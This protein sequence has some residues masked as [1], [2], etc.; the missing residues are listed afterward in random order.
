MPFCQCLPGNDGSEMA[1]GRMETKKAELEVTIVFDE[2][3]CS[4]QRAIS[5]QAMDFQCDI[6]CWMF[7][8]Y[9]WQEPCP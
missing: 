8:H 5:L 1:L 2:R 3:K 4:K 7:L 9:L 6:I